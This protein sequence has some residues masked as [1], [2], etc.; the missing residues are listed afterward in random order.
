MYLSRAALDSAIRL[1]DSGS[2]RV[3]ETHWRQGKARPRSRDASCWQGLPT[4]DRKSSCL[5]AP[6][7]RLR[8]ETVNRLASEGWREKDSSAFTGERQRAT[9]G[10]VGRAIGPQLASES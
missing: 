2:L 9:A 4:E 5:G 7:R 10:S 3:V 1:L 6:S 8:W